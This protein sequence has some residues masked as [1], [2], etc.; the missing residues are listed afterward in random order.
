MLSG[1]EDFVCERMNLVIYALLKNVLDKTDRYIPW[2]RRKSKP[3]AA[4]KPE[5]VFSIRLVEWSGKPSVFQ[6]TSPMPILSAQIKQIHHY[7]CI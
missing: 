5:P 2:Q 4:L 7:L 3:S 6:M 1:D